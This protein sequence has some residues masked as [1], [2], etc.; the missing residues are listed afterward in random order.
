MIVQARIMTAAD[1][2]NLTPEV[3]IVNT[4]RQIKDIFFQFSEQIN[5]RFHIPADIQVNSNAAYNIV[6]SFLL[7]YHRFR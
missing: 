3:P 7:C 2:I 6:L 4:D 1:D 5:Q